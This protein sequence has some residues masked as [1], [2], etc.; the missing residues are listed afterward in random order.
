VKKSL[1]IGA[2]FCILLKLIEVPELKDDR[3]S[4]LMKIY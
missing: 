2:F 1:F 4:K 3:M